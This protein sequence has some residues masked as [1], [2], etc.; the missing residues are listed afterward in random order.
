MKKEKE[1]QQQKCQKSKISNFTIFLTDLV[2]TLPRNIHEV[3]GVK[4]VFTFSREAI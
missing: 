2:E 3:L 4:L 1:Q